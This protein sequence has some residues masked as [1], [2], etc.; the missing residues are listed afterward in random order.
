MRRRLLR[1][2]E[3]GVRLEGFLPPMSRVNSALVYR[4]SALGH[5]W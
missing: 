4:R 3:D 1:P 2:K 5:L